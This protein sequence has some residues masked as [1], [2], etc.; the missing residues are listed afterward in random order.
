MPLTCS[1]HFRSPLSHPFIARPS[2]NHPLG[3][4]KYRPGFTVR[5]GSVLRQST[6]DK[7][8]K[9]IIRP[10]LLQANSVHDH[11]ALLFQCIPV[12]SNR[13]EEKKVG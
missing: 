13:V 1:L 5:Q 2:S 8:R 3:T 6:V 11:L 12:M 4:F 7:C 9:R 10:F